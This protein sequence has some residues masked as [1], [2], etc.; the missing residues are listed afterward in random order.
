M[1]AGMRTRGDSISILFYRARALAMLEREA[2][3][4][5]VLSGLVTMAKGTSFENAVVRAH[6]GLS[7][8]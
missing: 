2:D 1:L 4:C 7:C 6:E 5:S 3:A 8:Q